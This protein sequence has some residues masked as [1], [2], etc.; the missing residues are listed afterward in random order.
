MQACMARDASTATAY[1]QEG[2]CVCAG[3]LKQR[4]RIRKDVCRSIHVQS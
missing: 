4:G 1:V 2:K 3:G